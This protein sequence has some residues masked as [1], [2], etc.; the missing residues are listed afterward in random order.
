MQTI[1]TTA[2]TAEDG[3]LELRV[4]TSIPATDVDVT[5]VVAPS[6]PAKELD[7]PQGFI[8]ATAGAWVGEPF[9][10]GDQGEYPERQQLA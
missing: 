4:R 7:W 1:Q 10:R 9:V 2:Q 8:E 3:T 6:Q 5:V